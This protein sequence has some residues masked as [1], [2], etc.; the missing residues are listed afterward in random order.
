MGG[1]EGEIEHR[2]AE[3][4]KMVGALRE[5]FKKG[6]SKEVKM[7]LDESVF[8]PVVTY[9]CESWVMNAKVKKKIGVLEMR[10]LREIA[11]VRRV[12]RVRNTRVRD[13]CGSDVSLIGLVERR[14]L[15]WFGHLTRV[16]QRRLVKK[17]FKGEIEGE[18]GRGRP[19]K[20]WVDGVKEVL[21]ELGLTWDEAIEVARDRGRWR[22]VVG[23]GIERRERVLG[24]ISGDGG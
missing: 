22:E 14:V 6:L 7:R 10:M 23:F 18:R 13:L 11:G 19:G 20:R 15:R 9:G 8:I 4:S 21:R 2:I 5:I 1:M 3:G 24:R 16:N 12:D 17:V